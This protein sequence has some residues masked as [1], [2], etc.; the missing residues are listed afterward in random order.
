MNSLRLITSF[1]SRNIFR[2]VI[3]VRPLQNLHPLPSVGLRFPHLGLKLHFRRRRRLTHFRQRW[4]LRN[5]NHWRRRFSHDHNTR[6]RMRRT[7]RKRHALLHHRS[8]RSLKN[9][10]LLNNHHSRW[11][12]VLLRSLTL[13]LL[14]LLR[15]RRRRRRFILFH[16]HLVVV[17]NPE[18]NFSSYPTE[19]ASL[20]QRVVNKS[21]FSSSGK[22]SSVELDPPEEVVLAAASVAELL[23]VVDLHFELLELHVLRV[24]DDELERLVPYRVQLLEPGR[25]SLPLTVEVRHHVRARAALAIFGEQVARVHHFHHQSPYGLG[26]LLKRRRHHLLIAECG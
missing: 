4:I 8:T 5:M 10:S 23:V 6:R 21:F 24:G 19:H 22:L 3:P 2:Q 13:L 1:L 20:L 16:E 18:A 15:R 12:L 14:L 7:C 11:R 25:G 17:I 26:R 9:T